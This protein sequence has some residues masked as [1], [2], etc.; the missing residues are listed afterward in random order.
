MNFSSPGGILQVTTIN[1]VVTSLD[2][3]TMLHH[4]H[5]GKQDMFLS[6]LIRTQTD[7]NA[8]TGEVMSF[9]LS[10][11]VHPKSKE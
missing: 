9:S 4:L 2:I 1:D 7:R 6:C 8:A 5:T 3:L 11:Y 10:L